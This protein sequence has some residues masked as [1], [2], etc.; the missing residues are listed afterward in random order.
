MLAY[1]EKYTIKQLIFD[2][3]VGKL[4]YYVMKDLLFNIYL[5]N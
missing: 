5:E 2:N 4:L 1:M 3:C